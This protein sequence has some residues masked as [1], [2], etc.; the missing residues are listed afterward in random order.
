MMHLSPSSAPLQHT[1]TLH[2]EQRCEAVKTFLAPYL[3]SPLRAVVV[4]GS[5][6]G[7]LAENPL[8]DVQT[9]IPYGEIPHFP[10]STVEGHAGELILATLKGVDQPATIALM[11]GR[12]HYYEGYSIQDVVFPIQALRYCG[13][14]NVVLS[15][16]AGG[17]DERFYPGALMWINDQINLTGNSPLIGRNPD[18]LGPRFFDMTQ[19]F[20]ETLKQVAMDYASSE[21]FTLFEGV[22]AGVTGPNYE[23]PAEIRMMK[24]LG[25]SAVGM[26]TVAEVLAARHADMRVAA[27]SCISNLAAGMQ[28]HNLSHDEVMAMA[29]NNTV[30]VRF[31]GLVLHLLRHMLN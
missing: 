13:A 6:L 17:M 2:L 20:D 1:E 31:Q 5:G 29:N 18:F 3:T 21:G 30:G 22:Y 23:T 16:A 4:L 26:S 25:A 14:T 11:K 12:F 28:G 27:I 19:P 10:V 24:T 9:R 15:N 8:L 7:A